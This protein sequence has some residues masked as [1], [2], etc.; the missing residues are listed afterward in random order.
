[1]CTVSWRSL[2]SGYQLIFNR[3][4]Q[5]TRSKARLPAVCASKNVSYLAPLDPEGGGT[6]IVVNEVGFCVFLLNYYAAQVQAAFPSMPQSRGSLP[7][8][9]AHHG[10]VSEAVEEI[11]I[12]NLEAYRPF[13]VGFVDGNGASASF[14]WNGDQLLEWTREKPFITTSSFKAQSV[15]A[16]RENLYDTILGNS[17]DL[18][19][20]HFSEAHQNKAFNPLMSRPDAKTHCVSVIEVQQSEI[21][22]QYYDLMGSGFDTPEVRILSRSGDR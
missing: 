15:Q 20:L 2:E 8:A 3:D 10:K 1:M 6:W 17:E 22:Y 5:R 11:Q 9:F 12:K 13:I 21:R 14:A 4:E 7:V 16:Y 19:E 18:L